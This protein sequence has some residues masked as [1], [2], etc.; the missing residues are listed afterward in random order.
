MVL[1]GIFY[2]G[3]GAAVA[4]V[5]VIYAASKISEF[6]GGRVLSPLTQNMPAAAGADTILLTLVCVGAVIGW[7]GSVL[8]IRRFLKRA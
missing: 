7:I 3:F 1:E 4:A 8:S 6:V 5:V 2:G